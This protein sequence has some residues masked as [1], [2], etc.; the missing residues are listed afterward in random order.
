MSLKLRPGDSVLV[1][2]DHGRLND[3]AKYKGD[4]VDYV[5][6]SLSISVA[7]VL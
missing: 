7:G 6:S 4:S 2:E 3:M 5:K 1:P